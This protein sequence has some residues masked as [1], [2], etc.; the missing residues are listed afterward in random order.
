MS[1]KTDPKVNQHY[2]F[3][4]FPKRIISVA[5]RISF[6]E[7]GFTYLVTFN[8]YGADANFMVSLP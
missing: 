3:C 5:M 6:K 1:G 2:P 7:S 8:D 4:L